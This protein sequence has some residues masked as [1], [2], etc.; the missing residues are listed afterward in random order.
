MN[1]SRSC[2]VY[3]C[4]CVHFSAILASQYDMQWQVI[5]SYDTYES[6]TCMNLSSR[7]YAGEC[8][9][10]SAMHSKCLRQCHQESTGRSTPTFACCLHPG[11]PKYVCKLGLLLLQNPTKL[12]FGIA[13]RRLYNGL[14]LHFKTYS[15][16]GDFEISQYA[17]C[18]NR[19]THVSHVHVSRMLPHVCLP[20]MRLNEF[21]WVMSHTQT[22]GRTMSFS[23]CSM[24]VMSKMWMHL[25]TNF[26]IP[27]AH[28]VFTYT[29]THVT[30]GGSR[31]KVI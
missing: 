13:F 16:L 15:K 21:E 24:R 28:A 25:V 29:H 27:T 14:G 2:H 20:W 9:H 3:A 18:N 11:T 12:R 23:E 10:F 8:V 30:H 7:V 26:E 6:T 22:D 4:E 5:R 31:I 17:I 1:L 19:H